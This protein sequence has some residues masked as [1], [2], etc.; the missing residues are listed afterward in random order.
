MKNVTRLAAVL[1]A[2]LTFT[3]PS[4]AQPLVT[5]DTVTVGDAGNAA[6]SLTGYGSVGYEYN[7]GQYEVTIG[8]Y[9]SFLNAVATGIG[10][11]G[12][13]LWRPAMETDFNSRGISRT[14]ISG[15]GELGGSYSYASIGSGA[16]PIAAVTWFNAARFANWMNNGATIGAS[17]ETG[18]YTLA[19]ATTGIFTKNAGATYWIPDQDE[20]YKAAYYKGGGTNSGYWLYPT[21]S[22]TAPGNT[23]G[24]DANQANWYDGDFSV[25]QDSNYSPTQNYLTEAGL[26]S[27]SASAYGT[28]DQGGNVWEWNGAVV[29]D[30]NRGLNGGSWKE[31]GGNPNLQS[32]YNNDLDPTLFGNGVG[33]RVATVPEPSTYV[34]VL[35]GAGA[36]YF[37]KRRKRSV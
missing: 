31:D 21:Q 8:Q 30:T 5:I 9:T 1:L 23:I 36:V 24:G 19:G 13:D 33:F 29:N 16:R 2:A 35:M 12:L 27:N 34:L 10:T 4:Q 7:I 26:F 28:Y 11:D 37:W 25:T 3:T 20:W 22:D 32:T 18:A 17:T 15:E 14:T 6:D